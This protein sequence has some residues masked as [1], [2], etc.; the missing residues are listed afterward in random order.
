M[1]STTLYLVHEGDVT[2]LAEA[3]ELPPRHS[4][5]REWVVCGACSPDEAL[6]YAASVDS[7]ELDVFFELDRLHRDFTGPEVDRLAWHLADLGDEPSE[8]AI[9]AVRWGC[10]RLDG[11]S[12]NHATGRR[13]R[14][15]SVYAAEERAP[16]QWSLRDGAGY[17]IG[18]LL[19][20][21]EQGKVPYL[22]RGDR[23]G[24]GSDGEPL[25]ANV[26]LIGRLEYREGALCLAE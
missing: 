13:E 6:D 21:V 20:L 18:T 26:E 19:G 1:T 11:Q 2:P 9:Y 3:E 25:L 23:V 24:V 8:A 10:P 17:A 15:L 14:G 5:G 4:Y 16:G 22:V 12:I 7:E